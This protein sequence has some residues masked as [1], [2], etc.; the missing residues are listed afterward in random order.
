MPRKTPRT[1]AQVE[2]ETF[3]TQWQIAGMLVAHSLRPLRRPLTWKSI[4]REFPHL[5]RSAT[6]WYLDRIYRNVLP[7]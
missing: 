2:F 4:Q 7:D 6:H 3:V 1:R 5:S